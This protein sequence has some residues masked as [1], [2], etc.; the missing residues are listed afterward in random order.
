MPSRR[1]LTAPVQFPLMLCPLL[2]HPSLPI[3]ASVL[4]V[5][6]FSRI[7]SIQPIQGWP[8]AREHTHLICTYHI[9][10]HRKHT[11]QTKAPTHPGTCT[12]T[13]HTHTHILEVPRKQGTTEFL[14]SMWKE[15]NFSK[16][17]LLCCGPPPVPTQ[18][19][20]VSEHMFSVDYVVRSFYIQNTKV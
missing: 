19:Q 20:L 4:P 14:L 1:E 15:Q 16:A 2:Y 6:A 17:P 9:D 10:R 18:V 12:H 8:D 5:L 11:P 3:S 7:K 13:Q